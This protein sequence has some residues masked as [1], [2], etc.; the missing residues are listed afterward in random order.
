MKLPIPE[1]VHSFMLSH[2]R[3]KFCHIYNQV[4]SRLILLIHNVL[5]SDFLDCSWFR[6][7]TR[8]G[9]E[10][11]QR[12][13]LSVLPLSGYLC[14]GGYVFVAIFV[15]RIRQKLR[16]QFN[17]TWCRGE[18]WDKEEHIKL[19]GGIKSRGGFTTNF[20]TSLTL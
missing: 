4:R 15:S 16:S 17:G 10:P 6:I 7:W 14:Q 3:G 12:E 8:T 20:S 5:L 18:I 1:S 19:W 9:P 11:C 2:Q 13:P